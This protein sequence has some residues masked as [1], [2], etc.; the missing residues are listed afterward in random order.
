MQCIFVDRSKRANKTTESSNA[1]TNGVALEVK[2]RMIEIDSGEVPGCRPMLLFPEGTTT[3]GHFLLPFKTGAF[4]AG[5]PLQPVILRY[6]VH[7]ISPAWE[8]ISAARHIFL[9][10]ANPV[11]SVTCYELPVYVPSPEERAN[12]RLYA[13]NLRQSMV[14]ECF[15]LHVECRLFVDEPFTD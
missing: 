14:G 15:H 2:A 7:S 12:P 13:D 1:V 6:D 10:L 3:N 5:V 9:M 4:L 11:H 8:S